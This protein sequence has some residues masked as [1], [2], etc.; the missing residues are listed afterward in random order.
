MSMLIATD[1]AARP[2]VGPGQAP[3]GRAQ[4]GAI[5]PGGTTSRP[6]DSVQ[7]VH[8]ELRGAGR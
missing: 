7:R 6:L 8:Q 3:D 5:A 4:R 1:G 2:D